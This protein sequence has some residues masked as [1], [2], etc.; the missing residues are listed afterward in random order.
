[1]VTTTP[2][3][4]RLS[5]AT[6]TFLKNFFDRLT[7]ENL[8]DVLVVLPHYEK[9]RIEVHDTASAPVKLFV[10]RHHGLLF[11]CPDGT[12]HTLTL[13]NGQIRSV[14]RESDMMMFASSFVACEPFN[15]VDE[16]RLGLRGSPMEP[17]SLALVQLYCLVFA[18]A[19]RD[20]DLDLPLPKLK[21]LVRALR[22]LGNVEE[23]AESVRH[24]RGILQ[25]NRDPRSFVVLGLNVDVTGSDVAGSEG[26][27]SPRTCPAE[28]RTYSHLED[29]HTPTE[30]LTSS[31]LPHTPLAPG[32]TS[33]AQPADMDPSPTPSLAKRSGS[34]PKTKVGTPALSRD[35]TRSGPDSTPPL[36]LDSESTDDDVEARLTARS[37]EFLPGK[38]GPAV[39]VCSTAPSIHISSGTLKALEDDVGDTL[40]EHLPTLSGVNFAAHGKGQEYLHLRLKLGTYAD[41]HGPHSAWKVWAYLKPTSHANKAPSLYIETGS[42]TRAEH[43]AADV[44]LTYAESGQVQLRFPFDRVRNVDELKAIVKYYFL[45]A[46]KDKLRGFENH[47]IPWN[48]TFGNDMREICRR[49]EAAPSERLADLLHDEPAAESVGNMSAH[50]ALGRE[51][52][53]VSASSKGKMRVRIG[54]SV[55]RGRSVLGETSGNTMATS[56]RPT[57]NS[58]QAAQ[59]AKKTG[60][61]KLPDSF[62][63]TVVGDGSFRATNAPRPKKRTSQGNRT[64]LRATPNS[65]LDDDTTALGYNRDGSAVEAGAAVGNE[66]VSG[67]ISESDE[68]SIYYDESDSEASRKVQKRLPT[69]LSRNA[70]RSERRSAGNQSPND[71]NNSRLSSR[72]KG[73]EKES[74]RAYRR[75]GRPRRREM[76]HILSKWRGAIRKQTAEVSKAKNVARAVGNKLLR[77]AIASSKA[78]RAL[79]RHVDKLCEMIEGSTN[80]FLDLLQ[81]E[82]QVRP[83]SSTVEG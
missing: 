30:S 1:M 7:Q 25:D 71:A 35:S 22:A 47:M 66:A 63:E 74:R 31:T 42:G 80:Q 13:Y 67:S 12:M 19:E 55:D 73:K 79:F 83:A 58:Q 59:N 81:R 21:D 62:I 41:K 61:T 64:S 53:G 69:H 48:K 46:A 34:S 51:A 43:L 56:S 70:P 20:A 37:L 76:S 72:K 3:A 15:R 18:I 28:L 17:M 60:L 14:T 78:H 24:L 36:E 50:A 33:T 45:H 8:E 68:S 52:N 26:V 4:P 29:E 27:F 49:V 5:Q 82:Q 32:S 77:T 6:K 11:A 9:Q 38:K 39:P 40:L 57:W 54:V 75:N 44:L 65:G 23:V 16:M 2:G 10:G